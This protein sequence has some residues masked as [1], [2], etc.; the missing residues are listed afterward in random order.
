MARVIEDLNKAMHRLFSEEKSAY[1]IGEDITD[2][3]GGAFKV[4]KGL[5]TEFPNRVVTTPISEGGFMGVAAGLAIAGNKPIVE[6]MFGD[7]IALA[8]DQILNFISKSATMYGKHKEMH[9][10]V[11]CPIGGN[12][13]YGATHSQSLQKHFIGIPNLN[14]F[15]L[16]PFHD[17]YEVLSQMLNAS[18]PAIFFENKT[19]YTKKKYENGQVDDLFS[20]EL[21]DNDH[22]NVRVSIDG[23]ESTDNL[24]ITPGGSFDICLSAA[25]QLFMEEEVTTQII[26]PSK[27][28]PFDIESIEYYIENAHQI[29]IVEEGTAGGTW[30]TEVAS[31]IYQKMWGK[32]KNRIKLV[33]SLNSIIP[34]SLHLEKQVLVQSENIYS[35][36]KEEVCYV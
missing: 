30:G 36:M 23:M 6:I 31:V 3:Y 28:Y 8:F 35:A 24:I 27:L 4:S 17:N 29:I 1:L 7:F 13:G 15:E 20:Y 34:A 9:L 33:N 14:L 22:N 18:V 2:P 21:I 25:E 26:I 16:T 12:R 5:S 10:L 11:R 19:L 32:L